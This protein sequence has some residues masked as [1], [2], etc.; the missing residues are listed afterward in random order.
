VLGGG[1]ELLAVAMCLAGKS[2]E[3]ETRQKVL[4]RE[5]EIAKKLEACHF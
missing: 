4:D 5:W 2:S 1:A 3:A